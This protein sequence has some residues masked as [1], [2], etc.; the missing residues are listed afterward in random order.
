VSLSLNI[1]FRE[2]ASAEVRRV[3]RAMRPEGVNRVAARGATNRL[4]SHFD[5]LQA[6]RRN[7]LGGKP[8]NFYRGCRDSTH[9]ASATATRATIAISQIGF[10][11]R[12]LGGKIRPGRSI[13]PKTGRPTQFIAFPVAK[14]AYGTRPAERNDL[15]FAFVPGFGPA[16]VE[17][18]ATEVR[19]TKGKDGRR[20]YKPVKT[21][22][23]L[24]PLYRLTDEVNQ[25]ADASLIPTR[26]QMATAGAEAVGEYVNALREVKP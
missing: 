3:I 14:D 19:I 2:S 6:T 7:Q 12:L 22:T 16:L 5:F 23:G 1:D 21:R 11:Q 8:T 15:D 24:V 9:I 10:A 17:A 26:E 18:R 4:R 25:K 20:T 13:N